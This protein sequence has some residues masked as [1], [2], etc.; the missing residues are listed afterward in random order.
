MHNNDSVKAVVSAIVGNTVLK[1][2]RI[3]QSEVDCIDV[4][5]LPK[6]LPTTK[7]ELLTFSNCAIDDNAAEIIAQ[8]VTNSESLQKLDLSDNSVSCNGNH[9]LLKLFQASRLLSEF[10]LEHN[11]IYKCNQCVQGLTMTTKPPRKNL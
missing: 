2:L 5:E 10:N 4:D 7:I 9:A 8:A 6:S 1:N 3:H 11:P